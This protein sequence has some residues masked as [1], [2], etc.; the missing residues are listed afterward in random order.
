M[1]VIE[2]ENIIYSYL[3]I[4]TE[5]LNPILELYRGKIYANILKSFI[6]SCINN[7]GSKIF[8]IKK[9]YPRTITNLLSSWF[10]TL[11]SYDF[12]ED[13]FFLVILNV[14]PLRKIYWFKYDNTIVDYETK[15]DNIL[16]NHDILFI[17]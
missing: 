3:P 8:S 16:D 7:L 9:S 5:E 4:K 1:E 10:F 2:K 11:Y 17:K 15:I 6:Y 12:K 14:N 13:P